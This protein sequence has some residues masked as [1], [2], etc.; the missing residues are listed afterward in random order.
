M[1]KK[2]KRTWLL[3]K[4]AAEKALAEETK[5]P[6]KPEAPKPATEQATPKP[7]PAPAAPKAKPAAPAV[8][9]PKAK[10]YRTVKKKANK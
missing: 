8:E 4:V 6:V 7:K 9:K 1:G 10:S 2:W 5:A 3:R